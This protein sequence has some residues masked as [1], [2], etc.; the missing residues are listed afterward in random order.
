M[1]PKRSEKELNRKSNR[2][3]GRNRKQIKRW[4]IDFMTL[5]LKKSKMEKITRFKENIPRLTILP[6]LVKGY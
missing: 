6:S 5:F 4:L 3:D 1:I 2:H